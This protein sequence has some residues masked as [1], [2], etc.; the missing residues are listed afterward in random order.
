M[1]FGYLP[2]KYSKVS[3]LAVK[4]WQQN[5]THSSV[6]NGPLILK[7]LFDLALMCAA[8]FIVMLKSE[9]RRGC[10]SGFAICLPGQNRQAPRPHR[11]RRLSSYHRCLSRGSSRPSWRP[12]TGSARRSRM[13]RRI[14]GY[15]GSAFYRMPEPKRTGMAIQLPLLP[16]CVSIFRLSSSSRNSISSSVDV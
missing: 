16:G 13:W 11:E 14:S 10:N 3:G 12:P 8:F 9:C 6:F 7:T 5:S 15:P 4:K 1:C 2:L